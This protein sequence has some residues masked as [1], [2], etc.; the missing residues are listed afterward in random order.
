M[1]TITAIISVGHSHMYSGGI[2]PSHH[3]FLSENDRPNLT[4]IEL[5][6]QNPSLSSK[7]IYVFPTYDNLVEDIFL[8]IAVYILKIFDIEIDIYTY[9]YASIDKIL[10]IEERNDLYKKTREHLETNN[11]KVLFTIME[12]SSLMSS[13]DL[14]KTYPNE[15]EIASSTYN[16][17][18]NFA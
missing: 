7:V 2:I 4:I 18:R 9:E 14:I 17:S 3:I 13:I 12:G 6:I 10:S 15:I 5:P 8:T 1:G 16:S 11:I